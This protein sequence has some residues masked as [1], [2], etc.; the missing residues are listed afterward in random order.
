MVDARGPSER[1]GNDAAARRPA[2]GATMPIALGLLGIALI[3]G[4]VLLVLLWRDDEVTTAPENTTVGAVTQN[5]QEFMGQQVIVSGEI[6]EILTPLAYVIGGEAFVGGGEL[7]VVGPPP[8]AGSTALIEEDEV[9]PQDIIQV[10]G[11]IRE[12]NRAELEE[13]WGADFPEEVFTGRE[14]EPV[15]IGETITL[16]QRVQAAETDLADVSDILDN[17]EEFH[18]EVV[19][20]EGEITD[21]FSERVFVLEDGL[22]VI[23]ET[24]V[25]AETAL[26]EGGRVEVTGEV[27]EFDED[28]LLGEDISAYDGNPVLHAELIQIFE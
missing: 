4:I 1:T 17:P 5:P 13:E 12:F 6:S 23:D 3:V 22:I 24:G 28:A 21:V 10:S 7:L 2:P 16:T 25:V 19:S 27:R 18:G 20:V 15:L 8:A 14:G 11:E 26:L 9:Y